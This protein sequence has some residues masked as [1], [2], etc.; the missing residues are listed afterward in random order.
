MGNA[1]SK[2]AHVLPATTD[3]E[4]TSPEEINAIMEQ[5]LAQ[6]SMEDV[7]ALVRASPSAAA[8]FRERGNKLRVL[9]GLIAPLA[10]KDAVACVDR[11][12]RMGKEARR[13]FDRDYAGGTVSRFPAAEDHPDD[14]EPA[15]G[16]RRG[17]RATDRG[18]WD[19]DDL[20]EL[21]RVVDTLLAR[22]RQKTYPTL[23]AWE[24][25]WR[26]ATPLRDV[27]AYRPA[28]ADWTVRDGPDGGEHHY[29]DLCRDHGT[30][31]P[32]NFEYA[33]RRHARLD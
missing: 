6:T 12:L 33:F 20:C 21:A 26:R 15:D 1:M 24:A 17:P 10:W 7:D 4:A 19:L 14:G 13:A 30:E 11:R 9:R 27:H 32:A 31:D 3:V 18:Q 29:E 25:S 28:P 5:L 2:L 16:G 22:P 8:V 23:E